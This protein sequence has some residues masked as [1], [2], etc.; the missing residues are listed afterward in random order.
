MVKTK[1]IC[2]R[3]ECDKI[4]N[5]MRYFLWNYHTVVDIDLWFIFRKNIYT[6]K[7]YTKKRY[8]YIYISKKK[9]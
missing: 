4:N 9:K 7:K 8:I 2:E 3:Q 1:V 6:R 5:Q